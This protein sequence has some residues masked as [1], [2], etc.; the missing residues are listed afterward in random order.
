M[1]GSNTI[2]SSF[3]LLS[4]DH[5]W[6]SF[7]L[8]M[9]GRKLRFET[10]E[11]T[12][13]FHVEQLL[14][15]FTSVCACFWKLL[16]LQFPLPTPLNQHFSYLSSCGLSLFSNTVLRLLLIRIILFEHIVGHIAATSKIF[17]DIYLF[18]T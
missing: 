13:L 7:D 12:L 9:T 3:D 11:S 15:S 10:L 2:F 18:L 6:I 8:F 17:S 5:S 14:P 1:L 16:P 4:F